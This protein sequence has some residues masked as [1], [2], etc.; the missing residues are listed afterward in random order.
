[1]Y[2][3]YIS[4]TDT[5]LIDSNYKNDKQILGHEICHKILYRYGITESDV[6]EKI[7]YTIGANYIFVGS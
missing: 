2:G 1:V 6:N 4:Y 5:I 7:C 3:L